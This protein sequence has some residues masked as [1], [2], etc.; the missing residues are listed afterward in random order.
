MSEWTFLDCSIEVQD[1][2]YNEELPNYLEPRQI[3][4]GVQIHK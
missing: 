4:T 3:R 1:T 2:R